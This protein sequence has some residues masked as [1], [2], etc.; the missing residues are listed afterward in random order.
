MA[1]THAHL[2]CFWEKDPAV[3]LARAELAGVRQLTTL[4]DPLGDT[5]SLEHFQEQLRSWI[6]AAHEMTET[7]L[8]ENAL[9]FDCAKEDTLPPGDTSTLANSS[10]ANSS[11]LTLFDNIGYLV[12]VHPYGASRYTSKHT[13]LLAQALCDPYCVGVGEIGLDYHIDHDDNIAPAPRE[14]QISVMQAQ[15]EVAL[16]QHV[17]VELHLRN[18]AL[19][20]KRQAHRDAFDLLR[21]VGVPKAGCI[22]HCFC[23]DTATMQ[24]AVDLGCHI[25]FGGAATFSVNDELRAAF[26]ACSLDRIL[27]ETDCP[28]MAPMPVRGIECEPACIGFTADTLS[29]YR[30]E[31]RDEDP[32][33]ILLA[34][35]ENARHLL[36]LH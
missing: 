27:F 19:D 32:Q 28:Y 26:V 29:R 30:A 7:Y 11:P 15:L 31:K 6:A 18:D 20:S 25:A 10:V 3:C 35:Y 12:G 33:A 13:A 16:A 36:S 17:P 2:T 5:L 22:L 9:L 1:D 34:A 24:E 8:K 21:S 14:L 4:F 23:E